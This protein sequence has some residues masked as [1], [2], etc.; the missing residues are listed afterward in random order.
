MILETI[1]PSAPG[2]V[3]R[4]T[5]DEI[6]FERIDRERVK[7]D[8]HLF[9]LAAAASFIEI[10]SE[11][12][13]DNLIEFYDG[14]DE[15]V[16]WLRQS[17]QIQ[18]V[19]H[20]KALRRYVA[21]AWPDFDWESAYRTFLEEY[22]TICKVELLEPTRALEMASRCVVETA[23][24]S[25]Y[26]MLADASSE[27]VISRLAA[28]ISRDELDHYKHFYRYFRRYAARE[29][30]GRAA[31]FKALLRRVSASDA[32]DAAIAYKHVRLKG[33]ADDAYDPQ[34]YAD[35]RRSVR[36]MALRHFRYELA[37]KMLLKPLG[38]RGFECRILL[39]LATAVARRRLFA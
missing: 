34:D 36:A 35:F 30:P 1:T 19:Q 37:M 27:P 39:P 33:A 16:T 9:E 17:W 18:E 8:Q 3:L 22:L 20:G 11:T 2:S 15:V 10:T 38:L 25:F 31:I 13:T 4:W 32:E 14:D 12:Y 7:D 29:R 6:P 28:N 21:T 23:T 5:L 26:R 24:A